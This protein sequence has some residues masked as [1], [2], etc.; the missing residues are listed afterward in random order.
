MANSCSPPTSRISRSMT[1]TACIT[2]AATSRSTSQV[3]RTT[4]RTRWF[5]RTKQKIG[6][7][8][9]ME[10]VLH[11]LGSNSHPEGCVIAEFEVVPALIFSLR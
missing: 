3:P 5:Y 10:N 8:I 2:D 4:S 1:S 7:Y 11:R 9:F 6:L